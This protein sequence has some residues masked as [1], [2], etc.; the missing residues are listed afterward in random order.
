MK[1]DIP[2]LMEEKSID[3]IVVTLDE[4]ENPI[5][6]YLTGCAPLSWGQFIWKRGDEPLPLA[7]CRVQQGQRRQPCRGRWRWVRGLQ[8]RPVRI[9]RPPPLT[10]CVRCTRT[11]Q[12]L[13]RAIGPA[14]GLCLGFRLPS[15]AGSEFCYARQDLVPG[16]DPTALGPLVVRSHH[17]FY[18]RL[19]DRRQVV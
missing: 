6:N 17:L 11:Q 4:I 7:V 15:L 2:R 19:V 9:V 5:M 14:R 1:R 13:P 12:D 8:N 18:L 10:T 3:A 16:H